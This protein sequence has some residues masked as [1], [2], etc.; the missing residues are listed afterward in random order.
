MK[1]K[2]ADIIVKSS[3]LEGSKTKLVTDVCHRGCLD[4]NR[5]IVIKME[6]K[7]F[8][9]SLL[10]MYEEDGICIRASSGGCMSE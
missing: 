6:G 5:N 8:R 1:D 7:L 4:I 3:S 2:S 10:N 9:R